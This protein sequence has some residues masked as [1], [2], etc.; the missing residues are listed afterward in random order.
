MLTS[1]GGGGGGAFSTPI[2]RKNGEE[3]GSPKKS[4]KI[5]KL[6]NELD[7][8]KKML[9]AMEDRLRAPPAAPPAAAAAA[10]AAAF[11]GGGGVR[12][13]ATLFAR[14]SPLQHAMR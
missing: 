8:M 7:A 10:A 5:A 6:E 13:P 4:D 14:D 2:K 12:F 3:E 11:G 9:K 1:G